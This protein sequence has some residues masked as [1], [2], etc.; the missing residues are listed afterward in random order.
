MRYMFSIIVPVYN[1]RLY[2]R[3]CLDSLVQQRYESY[4]IVIVDDG[5]ND[6]S[7]TIVD[8]YRQ[9]RNVKIIHQLNGGLSSARNTGIDNS[10]GE[11]LLFVDSDDYIADD[12]LFEVEKKIVNNNFPEVL[13][14]KAYRLTS[15]GEI[16]PKIPKDTC[17]EGIS[18]GLDFISWHCKHNSFSACA[19]MYI[20]KRDFVKGNHLK[21]ENGL[22]HEDELWTPVL[23]LK[24]STVIDTPL[25]KYFHRERNDSI[26]HSKQNEKK[27]KDI[28][29]ICVKL[30]SMLKEYQD[31]DSRWL[32][33]RLA[34][35]YMNATYVGGE[36]LVQGKMIDRSFP[37]RYANSLKNRLKAVVFLISP[38]VY[39]KIDKMI[40]KEF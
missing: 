5:S 39:I 36:V 12:T 1:V 18:T 11:Y 30:S 31:K 9:Y 27:A 29:Y 28:F 13:A 3:E 21:F 40:K 35:L 33:D 6:G 17:I 38:L 26:T 4:E 32:H 7:E 10:E 8:K 22:L 23:L 24:A 2:L 34:M 25:I 15:K 20:C 16:A 19:P 14:I 37:L